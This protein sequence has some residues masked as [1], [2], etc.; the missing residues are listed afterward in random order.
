MTYK[1]KYPD[2]IGCPVDKY[3]GTMVSSHRYCNSYGNAD[4]EV[5]GRVIKE[6]I[7]NGDSI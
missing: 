7:I 4:A 5:I 2:C 1:D 6:N 3:C